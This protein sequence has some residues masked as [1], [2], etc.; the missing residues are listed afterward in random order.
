MS[1]LCRNN[2]GQVEI[3]A[4]ELAQSAYIDFARSSGAEDPFTRL[5]QNPLPT[6]RIGNYTKSEVARDLGCAH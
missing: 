3:A 2:L 4:H 1:Y 6:A 5:P